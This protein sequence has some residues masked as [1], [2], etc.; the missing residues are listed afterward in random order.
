M[1]TFQLCSLAACTQHFSWLNMMQISQNYK[2]IG[3]FFVNLGNPESNEK[4]KFDLRL[5]N[6]RATVSQ[7]QYT[8]V[9]DTNMSEN[10]NLLKVSFLYAFKS[11]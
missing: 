3:D 5:I 10:V 11:T 1:N 7:R 6:S 8:I 2:N 4:C 9:Y